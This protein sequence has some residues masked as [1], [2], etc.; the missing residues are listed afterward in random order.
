MFW[1]G[2]ATHAYVRRKKRCEEE[3]DEDQAQKEMRYDTASF[4]R[5]IPSLFV[6]RRCPPRRFAP[7]ITGSRFTQIKER[8]TRGIYFASS[9]RYFLL[10]YLLTDENDVFPLAGIVHEFLPFLFLHPFPSFPTVTVPA[11]SPLYSAAFR[12]RWQRDEGASDGRARTY[13]H[14]AQIGAN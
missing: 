10:L 3:S 5:E 11:S 14:S 13:V 6:A 8:T 2:Y 7:R 9:I 4:A 12:R 1:R